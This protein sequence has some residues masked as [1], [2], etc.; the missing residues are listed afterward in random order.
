[1]KII[2]VGRNY[3]AHAAELNNPVESDP[4]IFMKPDTALVQAR[5]PFFYPSFS[6]DIHYETELVVKINKVGNVLFYL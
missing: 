6:D 2:C 1:M 5:Q 3:A 4:V